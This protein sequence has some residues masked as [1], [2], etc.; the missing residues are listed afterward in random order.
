MINYRKYSNRTGEVVVK[1][2]LISGELFTSKVTLRKEKKLVSKNL[3]LK[4]K[5]NV[6]QLNKHDY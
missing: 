2:T 5:K 1:T 6:N 3:K 4:A